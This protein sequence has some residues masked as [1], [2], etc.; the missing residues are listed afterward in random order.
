[1]TDQEFERAVRAAMVLLRHL[2]AW[3]PVHEPTSGSVDAGR[4]LQLPDPF[5]TTQAVLALLSSLTKRHSIALKVT[6]CLGLCSQPWHLDDQIRTL[7]NFLM[8]ALWCSPGSALAWGTCS[9]DSAPPERKQIC[10]RRP[11]VSPVTLSP[12]CRHGNQNSYRARCA[13]G[14]S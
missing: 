14:L 13:Y 3:G 11:E 4:R 1:M 10:Q 7:G 8:L 12:E 9:S 2:H 5:S 6:P